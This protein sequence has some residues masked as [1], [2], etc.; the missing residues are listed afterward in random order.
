M[1]KNTKGG[2]NFKKSKRNDSIMV[3]HRTPEPDLEEAQILC[4]VTKVY[5]RYNFEL[6]ECQ[7]LMDFTLLPEKIFDFLNTH[8]VLRG[9]LTGTNKTLRKQNCGRIAVSDL[10]MVGFRIDFSTT[11]LHKVDIM[12]KY[13][14]DDVQILMNKHLLPVTFNSRNFGSGQ[15]LEVE[16]ADI[17]FDRNE[18]IAAAAAEEAEETKTS[19]P[20]QPRPQSLLNKNEFDNFVDD[21]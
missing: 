2:K 4:I 21:I 12:Y 11:V 7:G 20:P 13:T 15:T 17:I 9:I 1:P 10:V 18:A 19:V 8:P 14:D 16:E 5:S 6:A 3:V